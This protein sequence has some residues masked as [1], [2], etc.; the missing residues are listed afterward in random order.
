MREASAHLVGHVSSGLLG[1]GHFANVPHAGNACFPAST[2][3]LREIPVI[4]LLIAT[5]AT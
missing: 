5:V 1:R 3:T 4:L 2:L